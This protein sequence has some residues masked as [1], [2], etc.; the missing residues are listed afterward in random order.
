MR[1][2]PIL[3]I[4]TFFGLASAAVKLTVPDAEPYSADT[5]VTDFVFFDISINEEPQGRVIFGLF[6]NEVPNTVN[7]FVELAKK[8]TGEGYK[9]SIFHRIIPNF[10]VQGGDFTNHNGTGGK[11]IYGPKFADESFKYKHDS[12]VLSMANSGKDTNGS[13]FFIT[14]KKTNWLDGKHVVFGRVERGKDVVSKIESKGSGSG[15]VSAEVK[16]TNCGVLNTLNDGEL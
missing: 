9:G 3:S 13:Q 7:N 12:F 6:G 14:T 16:I 4:L 10:M 11:S 1:F 15:S 5:R 8:P 2:Q